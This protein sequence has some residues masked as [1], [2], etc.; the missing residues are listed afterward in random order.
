MS[1]ST[2]LDRLDALESGPD[3]KSTPASKGARAGQ[4]P[5]RHGRPMAREVCL[6]GNGWHAG[7]RTERDGEHGGD[8]GRSQLDP[9][10]SRLRFS[11]SAHQT[12]DS[13]MDPKS[14]S[15]FGDPESPPSEADR[16]IGAAGGITAWIAGRAG[17]RACSSWRRQDFDLE[18]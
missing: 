4:G 16:G 2:L 14:T 9:A 18:A 15:L 3:R 11:R 10:R 8:R 6:D 5:A 1:V 13:P 17:P 7:S 12:S